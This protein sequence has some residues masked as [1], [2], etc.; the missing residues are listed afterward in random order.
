MDIV[1]RVFA[2]NLCL[3][4]L[5]IL[6]VIVPGWASSIAALIVSVALVAWLLFAFERGRA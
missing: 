5:A 1:T 2:I 6:T 4:A 3:G